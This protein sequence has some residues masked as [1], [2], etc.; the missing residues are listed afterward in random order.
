MNISAIAG[1]VDKICYLLLALNFFWGL[2]C[3]ITA[4]RRLSQ[5]GFRNRT[6][7]NEFITEL[8]TKLQNREYDEATE[9]CDGDIRAIPSLAHVALTNRNL[10]YEP[11]RQLVSETLSQDL[12]TDFDYRTG[13]IAVTIKSGPLLGLFG[14]V[15]GMMAAFSTIGSGVKVEPHHIA[16]DISI[17]LICTAL[18][19]LTAIP[20]NF[21]LASINNRLRKLTES[22]S[23]GMLRVLEH[24][25]G[26]KGMNVH[27]NQPQMTQ[28]RSAPATVANASV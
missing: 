2:Y 22:I 16:R 12:L 25:K 13:W 5:F 14:T 23:A 15:M 17:A 1:V 6:Q 27:M 8:V 24:F 3:V 20:F 11:M 28:P 21:L 19:L 26:S 10:G 4:Y 18:G 9:M 7:E